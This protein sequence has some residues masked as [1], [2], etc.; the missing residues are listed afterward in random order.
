MV[1]QADGAHFRARELG[2]GR[3]PVMFTADWCGYCH[4]FAPLFKRFQ[5]GWIVDLT[6]EDL[7]LWD[8]LAIRVVPTVILFEDGIPGRRW[9]GVLLAKDAAEIALAIER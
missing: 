5:Q 9:S 3:V 2:A 7:P 1:N 4:R 8:E 6:D